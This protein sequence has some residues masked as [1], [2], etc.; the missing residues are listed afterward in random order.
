MRLRNP[1]A[2]AVAGLDVQSDAVRLLM[3]DK[4]K[5]G[6]RISRMA[7]VCLQPSVFN[8][9]MVEH[10]EELRSALTELAITTKMRGASVVV[11]LPASL[12]KA[13][14]MALGPARRDE[15]VK[16]IKAHLGNY[17]LKYVNCLL[18][19]GF[20][21]KIID[22]DIF[23]LHRAARLGAG[24]QGEVLAVLYTQ[25]RRTMLV[26]WQRGEVLTH[27]I[28]SGSFDLIAM[29]EILKKVNVRI[30]R[31]VVF[32]SNDARVFASVESGYHSVTVLPVLSGLK[33]K[34]EANIELEGI[35]SAS[36]VIAAG[37]A[38]RA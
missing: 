23:A 8:G 12:I 4:D 29:R 6:L 11:N 3:L 24:M 14:M 27:H 36:F 32:K 16:N 7:A 19:A 10:W 2:P 15:I 35:D 33:I 5:R 37:L 26:V 21:P 31:L 13:G 25:L 38:L 17:L 28:W 30:D 22:L 9:E 34:K 1:F 18:A 20:K